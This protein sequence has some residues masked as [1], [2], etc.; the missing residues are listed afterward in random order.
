MTWREAVSVAQREDR[1]SLVRAG[2][3]ARAWTA[4]ALGQ[5]SDPANAAVDPPLI[6]VPLPEFQGID[7]FLKDETAHPTGSLKHRLAHALFLHALCNGDLHEGS[8]VI[9]ASSGST[10]ISEAWFAAKLGL[11]FIAVVPQRTASAKV[12]AIEALGGEILFAGPKEDISRI[13][14]RVA[15]E[16]GGHF[17]D[18][19]SNAAT[20]TDWRGAN[21]IAETLFAQMREQRSVVPSWIVVGAGTGGTSTTIGRYIRF[22][23][24][25]ARTRLCVVDPEGSAFFRAYAS[26]DWTMT[27]CTSRV[28]EGIGRNR[29]EPSFNP[30]L[31]DQMISVTDAG[32]VAGTHWL[33]DRVGR[34]FGPST[35][36]NLIGALML[37]QAMHRRGETGSIVTLGCD[38]GDRYATTIYDYPWLAAA[39]IDVASWY[40]V[41][42]RL[43]KHGFPEALMVDANLMH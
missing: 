19:F 4:W 31:V 40:E 28:V 3:R 35:G 6:P 13:A 1:H 38:D 42:E 8:T 32:S 11:R 15:R 16:T 33:E 14:K 2:P 30:A 18:Q 41:L 26:G 9:E 23:T 20:V 36:T 21:N 39:E 7:F 27:G 22:K 29:V 12:A 24:E 25:Y 34:R 5:L 10:A 43:G 17:M 37:A